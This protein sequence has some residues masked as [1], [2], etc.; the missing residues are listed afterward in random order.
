MQSFIGL[1]ELAILLTKQTPPKREA[2]ERPA[3]ISVSPPPCIRTWERPFF[4]FDVFSPSLSPLTLHDARLQTKPVSVARDVPSSSAVF[5]QEGDRCTGIFI[6]KIP[7]AGDVM[8]SLI[9][10]NH[11]VLQVVLPEG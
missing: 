9:R 6:A 5:Q 10:I 8:R 7:E 1:S 3:L 11:A 4:L 2:G